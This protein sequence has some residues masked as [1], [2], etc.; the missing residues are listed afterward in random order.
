MPAESRVQYTIRGIPRDVDQA[1]RKK[2]HQRSTSLNRLLVEELTNAV[3]ASLK[4]NFRSLKPLAGRWK[5]D[6][7]FDRVL[8]EQRQIDWS[9]WR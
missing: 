1:L 9:L 4:R 7:E 2:A 5:E 8:A 3:G 6:P